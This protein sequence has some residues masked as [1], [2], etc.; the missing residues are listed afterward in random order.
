MCVD[1]CD[2]CLPE[3]NCNEKCVYLNGLEL[4]VQSGSGGGRRP[5]ANCCCSAGRNQQGDEAI[6]I[7]GQHVS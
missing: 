6:R 5:R 1:V 3:Q 4:Q 2:G 7:R